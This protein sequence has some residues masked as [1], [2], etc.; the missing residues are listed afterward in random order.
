MSTT[1]IR[2]PEDLKERLARAADRVGMSSHALIL[3]AIAERVD[4]EERRNDFHDT[5]ERRYAELVASG[6]T[7]PWSEMRNYLEDRLADRE[8]VRPLPRKLSR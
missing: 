1:T 7:I 4:D 5:A 6:E 3:A 8:T 2:L